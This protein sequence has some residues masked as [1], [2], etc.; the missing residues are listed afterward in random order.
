MLKH[1]FLLAAVGAVASAHT[2]VSHFHHNGEQDADCVRQAKDTNPVTD[3]ASDAVTSPLP[4]P[5]Y[6]IPTPN[7]SENFSF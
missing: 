3:L 5:L 4:P 1:L 6:S 2:V 7:R